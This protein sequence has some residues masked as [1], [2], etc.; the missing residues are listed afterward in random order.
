MLIIQLIGWWRFADINLIHFS[1]CFFPLSLTLSFRTKSFKCLGGNWLLDIDKM[2]TKSMKNWNSFQTFR[3][4]FL[5]WIF[6]KKLKRYVPRSQKQF[7]GPIISFITHLSFDPLFPICTG[8]VWS[9]DTVQSQDMVAQLP[10]CK[11]GNAGP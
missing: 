11:M 4:G 3:C 5:S 2:T 8:P 10:S 1:N 7:L 9:Q 6:M